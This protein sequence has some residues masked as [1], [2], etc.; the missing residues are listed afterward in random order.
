MRY[1]G[2]YSRVYHF[3][4]IQQGIHSWDTSHMY[5]PGHLSHVQSGTPTHVT[6]RDTYACYGPGH[7]H[8]QS[9]TPTR[10]VRDT[11]GCYESGTPTNVMSQGHLIRAV[12]DTSSVQSGTFSRLL[13]PFAP[14]S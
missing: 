10:A 2:L 6:V 11:Y 3:W 9:G 13:G 4:A 14:A 7:L 12:R 8:V 1:T 5:S